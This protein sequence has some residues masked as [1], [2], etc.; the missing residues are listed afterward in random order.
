M[1]D[2]HDDN[3]VKEF[4]AENL[5]LLDDGEFGDVDSSSIGTK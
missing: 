3:P 2:E 1:S 5:H 4:S